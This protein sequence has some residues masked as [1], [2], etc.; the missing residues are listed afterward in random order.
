MVKSIL[1]LILLMVMSISCKDKPK[2]SSSELPNET[3]VELEKV[4]QSL[5]EISNEVELKSKELDNA[6]D[7]LSDI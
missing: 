2:T 3:K 6:L 7:V 4:E 5:N 1:G